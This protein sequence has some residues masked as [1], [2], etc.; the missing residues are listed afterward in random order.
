MS[1]LIM[2]CFRDDS[3]FA[4]ECETL[5][6]KYQLPVPSGSSPQYRSFAAT[7]W[8]SYVTHD[9]EAVHKSATS[10][11][12]SGLFVVSLSVWPYQLTT[13]LV[14]SL[15]T[16]WPQ[17]TYTLLCNFINWLYATVWLHQLTVYYV[18]SS[19][20]I[21]IVNI[22][23]EDIFSEKEWT[24]GKTNDSCSWMSKLQA[25]KGSGRALSK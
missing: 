22:L 7:R 16:L 9:W 2:T 13:S 21:L 18:T 1:N 24:D 8:G 23:L 15:T 19:W 25:I 6:C 12:S 3:I 17:L 5:T 20:I 10:C 4:W 11:I 14:T